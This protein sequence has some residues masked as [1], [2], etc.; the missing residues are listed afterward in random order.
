MPETDTQK[1]AVNTIV[2]DDYLQTESEYMGVGSNYKLPL[3]TLSSPGNHATHIYYIYL[4]E[5]CCVEVSASQQN[6]TVQN[7]LIQVIIAKIFFKLIKKLIYLLSSHS[8]K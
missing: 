7:I 2:D 8:E 1:I 4:T 6:S 3:Q 5:S